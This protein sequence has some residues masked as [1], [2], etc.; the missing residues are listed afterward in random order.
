MDS[1]EDEDDG[2]SMATH[3]HTHTLEC[4]M[5]KYLLSRCIVVGD[6]DRPIRHRGD[7]MFAEP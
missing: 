3:T 4:I 7:D 1:D 2:F 6:D 5:H